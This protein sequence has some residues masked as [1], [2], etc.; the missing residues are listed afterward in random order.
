MRAYHPER[1][2]LPPPGWRCSRRF[3]HPGPCAAY[4]TLLTRVRFLLR[5][6]AEMFFQQ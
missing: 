6:L 4:P 3:P 2:E 5:A 1:C